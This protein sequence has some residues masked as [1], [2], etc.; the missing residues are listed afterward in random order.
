M[1]LAHWLEIFSPPL[2]GAA[3]TASRPTN[4]GRSGG[5]LTAQDDVYIPEPLWEVA[6]QNAHIVAERRHKGKAPMELLV[7]TG[8]PPKE[9]LP[10][11]IFREERE[12]TAQLPVVKDEREL[13]ILTQVL[14][15]LYTEDSNGEKRKQ[16]KPVWEI[17][18]R[19][20]ITPRE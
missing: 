12:P 19:I 15:S 3:K 7:S 17:G 10:F 1:A 8:V 14:G 5:A 16:P 9:P 20:E 18:Q 11:T 13:L 4:Q 6:A 2:P